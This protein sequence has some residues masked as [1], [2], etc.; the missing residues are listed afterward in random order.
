MEVL[1]LGVNRAIDNAP[2]PHAA[3]VHTLLRCTHA[4]QAKLERQ[5]HCSVGILKHTPRTTSRCLVA[6]RASS[7]SITD[8]IFLCTPSR[9]ATTAQHGAAGPTAI[10]GNQQ[11]Q[12]DRSLPCQHQYAVCAAR[13][14]LEL[15]H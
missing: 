10:L 9:V 15:L 7:C 1:W 3:P 11:Q 4:V 6:P 5:F 13:K 12:S 2:A 14:P 8:T